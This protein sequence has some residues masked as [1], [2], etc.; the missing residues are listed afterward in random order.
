MQQ[1]YSRFYF[2]FFSFWGGGD[3]RGSSK[4]QRN[5][6]EGDGVVFLIKLQ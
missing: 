6:N 4:I 1:P 2:L 3:G 5:P